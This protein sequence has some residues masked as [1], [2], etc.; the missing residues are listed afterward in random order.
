[1]YYLY[2]IARFLA[3]VLPRKFCYFIASISA[4]FKFYV[5]KRDRRAVIYNLLPVVRD[6]KKA[7][8]YARKVFENFAF[9]LVDFFSFPKIDNSFIEKYIRVSGIEYADRLV[10][11]KKGAVVLSAHI[12]NYELGAAITSFLGYDIYALALPHKDKR[13]NNFFNQQRQV[14]KVE[15]IS[16]GIDVRRCIKVLNDKKM[17]AFLGD[18]DFT[19]AK[20]QVISMFGRQV[21]LPV[22]PAFFTLRTNSCILPCFFI[23]ENKYFYRLIFEPALCPK[24]SKSLDNERDIVD[25]YSKILEKYILEYPEQWYMFEKYWL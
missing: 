14:F 20:G 3:L 1:M 13:I 23:R 19:S 7:K 5:S 18:R 8:I 12:G 4:D 16:T 25:Q 24:H 2:L 21:V 6:K 17:I 11:E 22:G 15:V 10:D 9:Y